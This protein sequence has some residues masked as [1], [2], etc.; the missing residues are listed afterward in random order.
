LTLTHSTCR[1]PIGDPTEKEFHFC[2]GSSEVGEPYCEHHSKVAFQP[3]QPRR[4]PNANR[5]TGR[6]I[7]GG[8]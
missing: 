7:S 4:G 1:W 8:Y 5:P 6:R 2:G 3:S